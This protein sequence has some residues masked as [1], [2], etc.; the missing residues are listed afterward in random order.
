MSENLV[1]IGIP[2]Y[3]KPEGLRRALECLTTQTYKNLEII[4]S[5]DCSPNPQT[6]AVALEF[7]EKDS[8][9]RYFYQKENKSRFFNFGFVLE[10]ATGEYFMWASDDDEWD[11]RFVEVCVDKLNNDPRFDLVF[12]KYNI[13]S[14]QDHKKVNL[15]HNLYLKTKYKKA[16]FMLLDGNLTHK[17]NM[18]YGVWRRDA[19]ESV[20]Q[21]A[22]SLGLSE[23][24]MGKGYDHAFLLIT[25]DMI[26]VYQ[27]QETLFTKRYLGRLIPGSRRAIFK[28]MLRNLKRAIRHPIT[29][30]KNVF[31]HTR[32]HA[33][34]NRL[35][36]PGHDKLSVRF[37]I[38]IESIRAFL[39]ISIGL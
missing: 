19:L 1:S 31:E 16:I 28:G 20:M 27:I 24:Y 5:N 26:D 12:T 18:S 21:R 8:R 29:Y 3:N 38:F 15:N 22:I 13:T 25:L 7:A 33:E 4:I 36:Y 30:F 23:E 2:A 6:E 17:A 39:V 32:Q 9:I 37:L 10:Q 35:F 11:P 34:L 14:P